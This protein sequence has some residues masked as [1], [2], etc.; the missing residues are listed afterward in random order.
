MTPQTGD[1]FFGTSQ[2]QSFSM[3]L[4]EFDTLVVLNQ[5]CSRSPKIL[6][7]IPNSGTLKAQLCLQAPWPLTNWW[8]WIQ[9]SMVFKLSEDTEPPSLLNSTTSSPLTDIFDR[10]PSL[11]VRGITNTRTPF[12]STRT[13]V[14]DARHVVHLQKREIIREV[15][16]Y[17][18]HELFL[19]G[20]PVSWA[21]SNVPNLMNH[22]YSEE[23]N[24]V[25]DTYQRYHSGWSPANL[26]APLLVGAFLRGYKSIT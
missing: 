25:L 15:A 26:C 20:Q 14:N 2:R 11:L 16:Q 8:T 3:I 19:E 24:D 17:T 7:V 1:S 10:K 13:L 12:T 23:T 5:K 21:L 18:S 22:L 4:N 6:V 9:S